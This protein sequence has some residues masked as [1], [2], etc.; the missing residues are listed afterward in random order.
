MKESTKQ[1]IDRLINEESSPER[2]L[3]ET[4][5]AIKYRMMD[6]ISPLNKEYEEIIKYICEVL[7][8]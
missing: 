6:H 7:G 3:D 4:Y 5:E 1:L 2:N 8:L